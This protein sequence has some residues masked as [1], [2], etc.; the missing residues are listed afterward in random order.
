MITAS[1]R[2]TDYKICPLCGASLD[3]GEKCDCR[4][5]EDGIYIN[6]PVRAPYGPDKRINVYMRTN[7]R[8]RYKAP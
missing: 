1:R 2:R 4:D 6:M 3:V 5:E 7:T 8:K